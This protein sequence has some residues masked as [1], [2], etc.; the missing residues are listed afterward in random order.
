M[1]LRRHHNGRS[2][3]SAKRT[4]PPAGAASLR[5]PR[6]EVLVNDG[7]EDDDETQYAKQVF[8]AHSLVRHGGNGRRQLV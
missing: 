2:M 5:S 1:D 4:L 7:C 8:V 3:R 6:H